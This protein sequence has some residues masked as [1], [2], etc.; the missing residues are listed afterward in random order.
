MFGGSVKDHCKQ[1]KNLGE[2]GTQAEIFAMATLLKLPIFV[3][4]FETNSQQYH[5]LCYK[6]IAYNLC[7]ANNCSDNVKKVWKL[8]PPTNYHIELIH[9]FQTHFDRVAP[10]NLTCISMENAPRLR[11]TADYIEL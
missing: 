3:F 9:S 5:W 8:V 4:T 10:S 2:W 7:I 11:D 1:M 6:P